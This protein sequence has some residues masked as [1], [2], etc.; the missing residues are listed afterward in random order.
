MQPKQD[1]I[2]A[3][4]GVFSGRPNPEL[5]LAGEV[6]Q[7][8]ADL[9]KATLGKEPIHPPPPARLGYYYG[10]VLHSPKELAE[11]LGLPREFKVYH[12]VLTEREGRV[13]NHWRDVAQIERFLID[14]AHEQGYGD[15]LEHFGVGELEWLQRR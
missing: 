13:Q 14:L 7:E 4:V 6:V 10:F 12:G 8:F 15:L 5:S 2:T 1:A 9:V 11:R 3:T